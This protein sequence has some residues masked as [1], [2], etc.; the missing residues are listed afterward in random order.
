MDESLYAVLEE[1]L[2]PIYA[3]KKSSQAAF[4]KLN[5]AFGEKMR[6]LLTQS[7][8]P[9]PTLGG[10]PEECLHRMLA[11]APAAGWLRPGEKLDAAPE[12]RPV[13]R[14]NRDAL[15]TTLWFDRPRNVVA[16]Q[17][18]FGTEGEYGYNPTVSPKRYPTE[19]KANDA[20]AKLLKKYRVAGAGDPVVPERVKPTTRAVTETERVLKQKLWAHP[21]DERVLQ[22][23]ADLWVEQGEPRGEFVQLSLLPNPTAEQRLRR[24]AMVKKLNGKL[25][26]PAREALT[27]WSFGPNGLIAEANTDAERFVKWRDDVCALNPLLRLTISTRDARAVEQMAK[28]SLGGIH[29]LELETQLDDAKLRTLAPSLAEVKNLSL[30]LSGRAERAFTPA[31]LAAVGDRLKSL[32]YLGLH[33][34][35]TSEG[36]GVAPLQAYLEVIVGHRGFQ[37]LK[38]INVPRAKPAQLKLLETRL[39]KL[40][41]AIAVLPY[42]GG[43]PSTAEHLTRLKRGLRLKEA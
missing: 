22:V 11:I 38:V 30:T 14:R 40:V 20:W 17:A 33:E 24:A 35:I 3:A 31:G 6:M 27:W 42:E 2:Q 39:P 41:Q 7:G 12:Q 28:A 25:I 34:L 9:V 5:R 43:A 23:L 26:G 32:E 29:F 13:R 10:D 18:I 15:S 19:A 8:L 37:Q 36:V 1:L 21:D 4:Q 16:T